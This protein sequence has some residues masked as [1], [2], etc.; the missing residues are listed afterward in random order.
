[1]HKNAGRPGPPPQTG[2]D[3]S[4][5]SYGRSREKE[6]RCS[7]THE[8]TA[9]GMESTQTCRDTVRW[10]LLY[11]QPRGG[12][13]GTKAHIAR[14]SPL[15][16][17]I[18]SN[19]YIPLVMEAHQSLATAIPL[20][21]CREIQVTIENHD[22]ARGVIALG[23]LLTDS[24]AVGKPTL[25]LAQQTVLSTELDRFTVKSSPLPETLR[26]AVPNHSKIQQFDEITV[27]FFPDA[28]RQ[29]QERRSLSNS[30]S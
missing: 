12:D 20:S 24:A 9:A 5:S 10:V 25:Y 19:N 13:P 6:S 22:N 23:L 11:F 18:R 29:T 1:M 26:F 16:L 15:T 4:V 8:N 17:N 28:E 14:G 30:S 21:C 27:I 2:W 7:G 3:I